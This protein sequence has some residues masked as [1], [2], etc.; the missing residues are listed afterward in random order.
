[1][2]N[3]SATSFFLMVLIF[4]CS[5]TGQAQTMGTVFTYQGK[6][7]DGGTPANG[8]YDFEFKLFNTETQGSQV[9]GALLED[10]VGVYEGN[11]RAELDFGGVFDGAQQWLQI[12][13]RPGELADPNA[14]TILAPRQQITPAPY[15]I[16]AA[17]GPGIPVPLDLSGSVDFPEAV[18]KG[19]NTGTGYGLRGDASGNTASGVFGYASASDGIGVRG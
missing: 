11:F 15:A 6:L 10:N 12:G 9:G 17:S 8:Q 3:K 18:V 7:S 19:T 13:V 5:Q 4:V 2:M 16:Y 14:Y 1:M